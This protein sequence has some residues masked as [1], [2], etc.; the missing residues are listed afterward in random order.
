MTFKLFYFFVEM[1]DL[2]TSNNASQADCGLTVYV[3]QAYHC[4]VT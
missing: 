1:N 2:L 3:L 4:G